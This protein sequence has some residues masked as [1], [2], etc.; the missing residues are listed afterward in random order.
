MRIEEIGRGGG[1]LVSLLPH[2][3]YLLAEACRYAADEL[4]EHGAAGGGADRPAQDAAHTFDLLG[5]LLD[6][7]AIAG[8]ASGYMIPSEGSAFTVAGV[9][10]VWATGRARDGAG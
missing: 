2:D 10:A 9:R 6:G 8:A 1:L 5:D 3:C 7:Y 4:A